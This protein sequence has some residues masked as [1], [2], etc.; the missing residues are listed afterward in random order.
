MEQF[1]EM[2]NFATKGL[3]S[4]AVSVTDCTYLIEG[5]KSNLKV[6]MD[7]TTHNFEKVLKLTQDRMEKHDTQMGHDCLVR[8][9]SWKKW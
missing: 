7:E 1:F 3:Q 5:L 2:C 8:K 4:P 9:L 6:F